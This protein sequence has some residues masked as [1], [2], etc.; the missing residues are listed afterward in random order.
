MFRHFLNNIM[1]IQLLS[2]QWPKQ[3]STKTFYI[4]KYFLKLSLIFSLLMSIYATVDRAL[5]YDDSTILVWVCDAFSFTPPPQRKATEISGKS[6]TIRI[7]EMWY[8]LDFYQHEF[9][10]VEYS[11]AAITDFIPIILLSVINFALSVFRKT[12]DKFLV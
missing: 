4:I 8:L 1:L 11:W 3:L 6:R 10:L 9:P 2:L 5:L 12:S 7:L